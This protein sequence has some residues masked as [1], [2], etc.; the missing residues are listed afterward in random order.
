MIPS[1]EPFQI[2]KEYIKPIPSEKEQTSKQSQV[3][4]P[5]RIEA[6]RS[7]EHSEQP[8]NTPGTF[9]PATEVTRTTTSGRVVQ[10]LKRYDEYNM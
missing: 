3:R 8:D 2:T 5:A 4:I 6:P 1:K 7:T 9:Q 10:Q